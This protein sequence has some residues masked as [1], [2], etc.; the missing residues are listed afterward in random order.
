MQDDILKHLLVSLRRR[1]LVF[2][3]FS[4][5]ISQL[6]ASDEWERHFSVATVDSIPA[7]LDSEALVLLRPFDSI[8]RVKDPVR[9]LSTAREKVNGLL[10]AGR[11]VCLISKAPRMAFPACPGSS[12]LEDAHVFHADSVLGSCVNWAEIGGAETMQERLEWLGPDVL[13]CLDYLLFDLQAFRGSTGLVTP[14]ELEAIRGAGLVMIDAAAETFEFVAPLSELMPALTHSISTHLGVQTDFESVSSGLVEIER[15]IRRALQSRAT[16]HFGDKWRGAVL[17]TE[18]ASRVADRA[19]QEL[20]R[21]AT[22]KGLRSP[23][24]WLTIGE[25][26]DLIRTAEWIGRLGRED[27][28]WQRFTTEVMPVR[29]RLSHMRFLRQQ[30]RGQVEYWRTSLART[31]G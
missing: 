14:L 21:T 6:L 1:R 11:S 3:Q 2:V 23:F 22:V 18:L 5:A 9:A 15:R 4:P 20:S 24:E 7:A 16:D 10:D 17:G 13:A 30:D 27:R 25:L 26:V 29:N 19:T 8:L 12:L 28:Y 31:I